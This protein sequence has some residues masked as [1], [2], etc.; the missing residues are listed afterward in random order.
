MKEGDLEL[1][2]ENTVDYIAFSYYKSCVLRDGVTMKTDT[3]GVYG[4]H[5]PY[6]PLSL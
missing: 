6:L 5:N 4:L 2:R 3:G 1:I